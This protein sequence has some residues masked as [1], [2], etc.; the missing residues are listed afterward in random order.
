MQ[1]RQDA[2]GGLIISEHTDNT[3]DRGGVEAGRA[4]VEG[5]AGLPRAV[6]VRTSLLTAIQN[7]REQLSVLLG[8][9]TESVS[10]LARS[11]DGWT[12][13]VEVLEL[14]RV[15]D[16]TSVLA[17]YIVQLDADGDVI[18]Y[19]RSRRYPRGQVNRQ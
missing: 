5:A 16:S 13:N 3:P 18:S 10:A 11:K 9:E 1:R 15:P 6:P 2:G 8:R 4:N 19:A 17:T 7:A 12:V 14:E